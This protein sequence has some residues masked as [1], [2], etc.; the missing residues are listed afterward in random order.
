MS[1]HALDE[2]YR[3]VVTVQHAHSPNTIVLYRTEIKAK[4][5]EYRH[6]IY[7]WIPDREAYFIVYHGCLPTASDADADL[8]LNIRPRDVSKYHPVVNCPED[9]AGFPG[10]KYNYKKDGNISIVGKCDN[11]DCGIKRSRRGKREHVPCV[12]A[13]CPIQVQETA[14][15]PF[16]KRVTEDYAYRTIHRCCPSSGPSRRMSFPGAATAICPKRNTR[17]NGCIEMKL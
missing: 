5:G 4:Y 9:V 11:E 7:E 3:G 16:I 10:R 8:R 12:V 15:V 1:G 14:H 17:S 2:V 6:P 13:R